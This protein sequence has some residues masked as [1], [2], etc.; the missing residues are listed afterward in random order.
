MFTL[1]QSLFTEVR[2]RARLV[3]ST[4]DAG[5][6][7]VEWI[8]LVVGMLAIAGIVIFAVTGFVQAQ[9]GKLPG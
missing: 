7:T 1:A 8:F 5:L 3:R 4:G 9:V 2:R 6:Q